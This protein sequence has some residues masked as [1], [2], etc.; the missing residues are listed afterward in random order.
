M[1]VLVRRR[2]SAAAIIA[3]AAVMAVVAGCGSDPVTGP[4]PSAVPADLLMSPGELP[5]GFTPA[6]LSVADLVAGN[7]GPIES[8]RSA[9]VTPPECRP[10]AD[11]DLNPQLTAANSAV[12]AARSDGGSLV[13]LVSTARRDIDA[14]IRSTTGRCAITTTVIG[15]GNL[16]GARIVTRYTAVPTP[17]SG[18]RG[19]SVQESTAMRSMVTTTLTDGAVSTQIGFA[20]YAIVTRPGAAA[21]TVQLTVGGEATPATKPATGATQPMTDAE[22][23]AAFGD[24]ISAATR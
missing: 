5:A 17:D 9:V 13:E 4:A 10:T 6:Q 8:A 14:D 12:L 18:E 2:W 7:R 11:A 15:S 16:R 23:A 21:V 1:H 22:F 24:A 3:A 19:S 20:G